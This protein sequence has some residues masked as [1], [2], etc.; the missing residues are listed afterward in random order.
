[1]PVLVQSP[2]LGEDGRGRGDG[3]P[4]EGRRLAGWRGRA[5][6]EGPLVG[7]VRTLQGVPG[8]RRRSTGRGL[9]SPLPDTTRSKSGRSLNNC[10][11]GV[12]PE[13]AVSEQKA[14]APWG[15]WASIEPRGFGT[16][17]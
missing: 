10:G 9:S 2:R 17:S 4:S 16:A 7:G 13:L 11:P 3:R 12:E 6:W 5:F 14:K 8:T 15:G 1:M